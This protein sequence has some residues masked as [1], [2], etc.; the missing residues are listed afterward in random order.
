VLINPIYLKNA[1]NKFHVGQ[2]QNMGLYQIVVE[3]PSVNC[4]KMTGQPCSGERFGEVKLKV[5]LL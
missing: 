1:M 4:P 3:I 5:M 2:T